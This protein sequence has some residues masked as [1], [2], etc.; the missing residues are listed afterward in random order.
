MGM[1]VEVGG[2]VC[3]VKWHIGGVSSTRSML[4]ARR[5]NTK[6]NKPRSTV[7]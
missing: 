6:Q 7:Q 5:H 1:V 4:V 2:N 3:Y